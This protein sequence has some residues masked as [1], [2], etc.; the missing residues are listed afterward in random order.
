MNWEQVEEVTSEKTAVVI[1]TSI[2]GHPIDLDEISIYRQKHPNIIILQDCAHSYSACWKGQAVQKEGCAA[3]YGS[4]ISKLITS[5]FGGM[6]TT[7]DDD[8]ARRLREEQK[9]RI[10]TPSFMHDFLIR[11]YLLVV[12]F[13]FFETIYGVTNFMEG[14][15]L[16]N[17]FVRYYDEKKI[18]MPSDYLI[19]ATPTQGRVGAIQCERFSEILTNRLK[20]AAYYNE[21]LQGVGDLVLPLFEDG[22]TYSHYVP[23]T[24][25]RDA[26]MKHS[27][28]RG[29][30]IGQLIEYCIP[31]MPVYKD[32]PGCRL[33]YP[34]AS[35]L[36]RE[37]INLP[38]SL[39]GSIEKA[40]QVVSAL[41]SFF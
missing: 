30:Q 7:D 23:Q 32:R 28:Q 38:V 22:A 31:E 33:N 12:W 15:G 14:Y 29:V 36:A 34:V 1:A 11:L 18:D 3:F 2:F 19:G 41:K 6:I 25:Y 35:R 37:T 24:K 9:A 40:S 4:N 17:R 13:S 27:L 16:L 21:N 26:I 5:I 10:K 8:L 39:G 20:V